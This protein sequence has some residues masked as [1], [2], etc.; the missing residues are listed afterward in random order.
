MNEINGLISAYGLDLQGI[1]QYVNTAQQWFQ[2]SQGYIGEAQG[3]FAEVTSRLSLITS[4]LQEFQ[5][6]Q[7]MLS[8]VYQEMMACQQKYLGEFT[9]GLQ[10]LQ[11]GTFGV[12]SKDDIKKV[13]TYT[14]I[15]E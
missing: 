6:N 12:G 9:T 11:A 5:M 1:Q 14:G 2:Q 10:M 3:H 15:A 13:P 7:G 4:Q 8:A